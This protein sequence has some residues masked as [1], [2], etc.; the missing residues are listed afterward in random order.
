MTI[1]VNYV[2]NPGLNDNRESLLGTYCAAVKVRTK[3]FRILLQPDAAPEQAE[4][5]VSVF[6]ASVPRAIRRGGRIIAYELAQEPL[7][8]V[9]RCESR[10]ES[11][12]NEAVDLY[13]TTRRTF[14]RGLWGA[15]YSFQDGDELKALI[16]NV[17][18]SDASA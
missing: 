15:E 4:E 17:L 6:G 12:G 1:N 5:V 10:S 18:A 11:A 13:I 14:K 9:V 16:T 8:E 7:L 3:A 2:L